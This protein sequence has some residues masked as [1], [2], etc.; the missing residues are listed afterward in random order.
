MVFGWAALKL[1]QE[2]I[3]PGDQLQGTILLVLALVVPMAAA[4][5]VASG[6][7][8][9]GFATALD[10]SRWWG[11]DTVTLILAGLLVVTVV[12][13]ML[14]GLGLVF[15]P[16]YKDFPFASLTGPVVALAILAFTGSNG[17]PHPGVAEMVAAVILLSAALFIIVNEGIANWQALWFSG[18]LIVLALTVLRVRAAPG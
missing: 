4:F 5:A 1:P 18:L 2:D 12:A 13:A 7:R 16:R 15:D 9:H 3:L 17:P 14:S 6:D 8:L 10:P 11:Q